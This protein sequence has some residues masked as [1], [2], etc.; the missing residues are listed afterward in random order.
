MFGRW[1]AAVMEDGRDFQEIAMGWR[2]RNR[3]IVHSFLRRE[4][5]DWLGR[6]V[7]IVCGLWHGRKRHFGRCY[8][9]FNHHRFARDFD[10][11]FSRAKR[12]PRQLPEHY[13]DFVIKHQRTWKVHRKSQYKPKEA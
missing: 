11:E 5:W 4:H 12:S 13:D 7:W 2:E 9:T 8:R 10:Q 1:G 6:D 3:P